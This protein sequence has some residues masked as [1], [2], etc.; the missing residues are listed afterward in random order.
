MDIT[1]YMI[2]K[3]GNMCNKTKKIMYAFY[4]YHTAF[5]MKMKNL[6]VGHL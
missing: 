6:Y 4:M 2:Q 1:F 3:Y 5:V